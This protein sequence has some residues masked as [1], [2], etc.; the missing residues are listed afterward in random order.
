MTTTTSRWESVPQSNVNYCDWNPDNPRQRRRIHSVCRL[1]VTM[2]RS[3]L[4][5]SHDGSCF[6]C[7]AHY[8]EAHRL[9]L[10]G[11]SLVSEDYNK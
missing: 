3:V 9:G 8:L 11:E 2:R 7:A 4:T 1:P 6:L 10:T 5:V